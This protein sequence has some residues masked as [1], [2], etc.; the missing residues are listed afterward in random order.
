M[1][2]RGN[3][4]KGQLGFSMPPYAPLFPKPPYFYENATLMIFKY[5]TNE[6]AARMVPEMV[7]LADPP[8]AGLVFAS[9]PSSNLGPYDEVVLFLDVVFNG[10][11]LQFAAFLY[12]TTDAAMAAG[13][14]MGGY[15]KKIARIEFLPGPVKTW[16]MERPAGLRIC[17]GT[18]RP[19]QRQIPGSDPQKT[20]S[21]PARLVLNYLT[22]RLIPSPQLGQPPSLLELLETHWTIDCSEVWTGPGS[23]QFTGASELDPLHWAPVVQPIVCELV[24]GDIVVDLNDQPSETQL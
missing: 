10:R 1:A 2:V 5:V 17:T 13:R 19:E 18:M 7:E 23:C 15:P 4:K 12:V 14:E 16:V 24:K 6:S 9:Y 11:A 8:T 22:L 20:A 3:L 21:S